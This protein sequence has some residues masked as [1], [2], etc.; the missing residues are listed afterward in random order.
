MN[1]SIYNVKPTISST[2]WLCADERAIQTEGLECTLNFNGDAISFLS[3]DN[4]KNVQIPIDTLKV[5]DLSNISG[6]S[7]IVFY[8]NDEL[9][10]VFV[11]HP[12]VSNKESLKM[13]FFFPSVFTNLRIFSRLSSSSQESQ[14]WK[15]TLTHFLPPEK[16]K[17]RK[18]LRLWWIIICS[19]ALTI[20]LV[21]LL[22][23]ILNIVFS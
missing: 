8:T 13:M 19:L 12:P 2:A 6:Q 10:Y 9:S 4:T 11:F 20:T 17:T 18:E 7:Q 22:I 3:V 1:T 16:I 21:V 14:K 5:A 23:T 15:S